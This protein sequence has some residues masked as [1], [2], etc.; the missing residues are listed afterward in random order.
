[1]CFGTKKQGSNFT[2]GPNTQPQTKPPQNGATTGTK[3]TEQP[4]LLSQN[5]SPP[6]VVAASTLP[7]SSSQP[8]K[9]FDVSETTHQNM[10]PVNVAIIIYSLYGH[11]VKRT[12]L[13]YFIAHHRTDLSTDDQWPKLR[14]LASRKQEEKLPSTSMSHC[15]IPLK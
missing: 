5:Q 1:M 12:F 3:A 7:S 9:P 14:K 13:Y 15:L 4:Q 6:P 8:P 2:D 11:V 10:A